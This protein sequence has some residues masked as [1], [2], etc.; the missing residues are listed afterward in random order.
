M[1]CIDGEGLVW[2]TAYE[3]AVADVV[4]PGGNAGPLTGKG[5]RLRSRQCGSGTAPSR[6]TAVNK[7]K[8]QPSSLCA[9]TVTA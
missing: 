7:A 2:F 1:A 5:V 9:S 4:R 8:K 6:L 3:V